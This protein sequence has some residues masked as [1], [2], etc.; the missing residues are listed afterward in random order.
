M[1]LR[2]CESGE[3]EHSNLVCNVGPV[4]AGTFLLKIVT[5]LR[6]DRDDTVSHSLQF[7]EPLLLQTGVAQNRGSDTSPMNWWVGVQWSDQNLYLGHGAGCLVF[8]CCYQSESTDTLTC[9]WK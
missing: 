4:P 7:T 8:V 1:Y 9:I 2:R 5:E 6:A 3:T